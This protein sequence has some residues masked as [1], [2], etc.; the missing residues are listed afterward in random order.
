MSTISEKAPDIVPAV[1]GKTVLRKDFINM[2]KVIK[3]IISTALTFSFVF[4]AMSASAT[5]V[6]PD[7]V[8]PEYGEIFMDD[9]ES[10][11]SSIYQQVYNARVVS[12]DGYGKAMATIPKISGGAAT[13]GFYTNL[14]KMGYDKD[15][16]T[17]IRNGQILISQEFCVPTKTYTGESIVF[18]DNTSK[19][20]EYMMI[21]GL[22]ENAKPGD[23]GSADWSSQGGVLFTVNYSSESPW[24]GFNKTTTNSGSRDNTYA[25]D[26]E[27][28]TWHKAECC[29]DY[30]NKK[31]SYY[32]DGEYVGDYAAADASKV[33]TEKYGIFQIQMSAVGN[34]SADTENPMIYFDNYS[35]QIMKGNSFVGRY[36]SYGNNSV[37]LKFN[38]SIDK[39]ELNKMD[40]SSVK[41][42]KGTDTFEAKSFEIP[43]A[44]AVRF[45]FDKKIEPDGVYSLIVGTENGEKTHIRS[46]YGLVYGELLPGSEFSFIPQISGSGEEND[47]VN[48]S[49][50]DVEFPNAETSGEFDLF[51]YVRGR[52][53]EDHD[54]IEDRESTYKYCYSEDDGNGGALL[55]FDDNDD[56]DACVDKTGK[57]ISFKSVKFPFWGSNGIK[58]GKLYISF[59]AGIYAN[60]SGGARQNQRVIFGLHNANREEE[61]YLFQARESDEVWSNSSAFL[62]LSYWTDKIKSLTPAT[63]ENRTRTYDWQ[64]ENNGRETTGQIKLIN[65]NTM[66]HYTLDIDIDEEKYYISCDGGDKIEIN[67]LPGNEVLPLYDAFVVTVVDPW[68][69]SAS[70][71]LIDNLH[72]TTPAAEPLNVSSVKFYDISGRE[73]NFSGSITSNTSKMR[74][75]FNQDVELYKDDYIIEGMDYDDYTAEY[76]E[77]GKNNIVDI[78]FKKCL[79]ND[80]LYKVT[81]KDS[82]MSS[83]GEAFGR[84]FDIA[85]RSLAD[86]GLNFA[87]PI[88]N[89][90]GKT[91]KAS[92]VNHTSE[93]VSGYIT[94]VG[95]KDT[96][97]VQELL[98]FKYGSFLL[99]AESAAPLIGNGDISDIIS[100]GAQRIGV[101]V[102][103]NTNNFK[104]YTYK[105]DLIQ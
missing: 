6:A 92:A 58:K 34:F 32:Y 31:I 18:D 22:S 33:I 49:F 75:E 45:Y 52:K 20:G 89:L 59:D 74:I 40:I 99:E 79:S 91:V 27:P 95:Y 54:F 38:Y 16:T 50:D 36:D 73:Q 105:T 23:Y 70:K 3:Q 57:R 78:N 61:Q 69:N 7:G 93:D 104:L 41:L 60:A 56:D 68:Q 28:D 84:S 51:S 64:R 71:I 48:I 47:I 5:Y 35:V 25:I 11:D 82:L 76:A 14:N 101:Y 13:S 85:F 8:I 19:Y 86:G 10:Y 4:T 15:F 87:E 62:G 81:I 72:I 37:D 2:K 21:Y 12:I 29:I 63:P 9:Y 88:I 98:G 94:I 66:H 17:C 80:T 46:V 30:D 65:D 90:S 96:D 55:A 83:Y 24:I 43:S 44:D 53:T 1:F 102:F 42:L 67:Y 77:S 100:A 103:D 39:N 26:F 97:G